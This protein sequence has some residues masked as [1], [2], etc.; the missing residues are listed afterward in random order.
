MGFQVFIEVL[1]DICGQETDNF[2]GDY[3][4]S[5]N[6]FDESHYCEDCSEKLSQEDNRQFFIAKGLA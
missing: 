6:N 5:E 2:E 3:I 4:P 1:C